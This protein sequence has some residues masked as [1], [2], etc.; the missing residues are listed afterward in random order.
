[1]KDNDDNQENPDDNQVDNA[2][3]DD[4][5]IGLLDI[6]NMDDFGGGS[7]K[8]DVVADDETDANYNIVDQ[9]ENRQKPKKKKTHT[10][11][12]KLVSSEKVQ[13]HSWF[14]VLKCSTINHKKRMSSV[15]MKA[16]AAAGSSRPNLERTDL[17]STTSMKIM[18]G[19]RKTTE[20]R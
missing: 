5:E 6:L 1:M 14:N 17:R 19:N 13:F 12:K 15:M 4:S 18:G 20:D 2:G 7:D 8:N 10:L 11:D 3:S 16:T 9:G